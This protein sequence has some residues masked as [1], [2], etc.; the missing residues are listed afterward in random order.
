MKYIALDEACSDGDIRLAGDREVENEG[1]VEIC[2][3]GQWGTVCDDRWENHDASVACVQLGYPPQS[4]LII[5]I[6]T[7]LDIQVCLS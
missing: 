7:K 4:M 5:K 3:Q 6:G 1:R 2:H